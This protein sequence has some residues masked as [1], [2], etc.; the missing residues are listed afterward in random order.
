MWLKNKN[1]RK[2]HFQTY[3]KKRTQFTY[4]SWWNFVRNLKKIGGIYPAYSFL[5]FCQTTVSL[6]LIHKIQSR[7]EKHWIVWSI[8]ESAYI[9]TYPPG[10]DFFLS[11]PKHSVKVEH[12]LKDSS[13]L[14]SESSN[15]CVFF[16]I[17]FAQLFFN[18]CCLITSHKFETDLLCF[19]NIKSF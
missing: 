10:L 9:F 14:Q 4:H 17:Y 6:W 15:S 7:I 19:T 2:R 5:S 13:R 3:N 11:L 8:V 12:I 1:V 18:S 16:C